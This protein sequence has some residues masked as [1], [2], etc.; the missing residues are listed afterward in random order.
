MKK[1]ILALLAMGT[2]A[3]ANAQEPRS[4]LLYG[5]ASL[6]TNRDANLVDATI[7]HANIGVGYQFNQNWT[8]GLKVMWGQDAE[9]AGTNGVLNTHTPPVGHAFNQGNRITDNLYALGPFARYSRYI[10]KSE[11]FYW[12]S[13]FDFDYQGG[14]TTSEG[15][16]ATSKHTGIYVGLFPA[17]GVNVGHGLCLNFNIGGINYMTDK[18]DNATYSTNTFNFTFGSQANFGISK[19]FNCGHKMHSHHEPGDEVHRRRAD[20]MEDEDDAAPKSKRKERNRDD[21][22]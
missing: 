4:I 2:I 20:R 9:K 19:N 7:W 6:H 1:L 14:Y 22:E 13:Q 8:L 11:T 21:D 12:F 5:D 17:L 15:D 3:T 18:Y 16:P 10:R